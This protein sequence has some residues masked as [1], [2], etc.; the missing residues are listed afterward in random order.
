MKT[1]ARRTRKSA[2]KAP[3]P[4]AKPFFQPIQAKLSV[5]QPGDKLEQEADATADRVLRAPTPVGAGP[6]EREQAQRA[7]EPEEAQRSA[8]PSAEPDEL[9]RS[10]SAKQDE[11]Q[12]SASTEQDE[13]QRSASAEPDELQRSSAHADQDELQRSASTAQDELQ[14]SASAEPDE[15]QRSSTPANGQDELQRT[16]APPTEG[17]ELQRS[18]D[19]EPDELQRKL[20]TEQDELQRSASTE[21]D[22]LQR[23]AT[24]Q[25]D[26]VQRSPARGSEPGLL[27]RAGGGAPQVSESVQAGI[28]GQMT[29][30]RK[31]D[32]P[33]REFMESRFDADFGAVR[34][35]DDKESARL[36]TRLGARA[37]TTRGHIFFGE[38]QYSPGT[39]EGRRLLAH[40]LTHTLQQGVALQRSPQVSGSAPATQVQRLGI[41]DALDYFAD[42]AL[43]LPGFRMLTVVL[44]FNPINMG[45]VDR[46]PGNI[47]RALIELIPGA[48][49]ITSALEKHGVFE[50]AGNWVAQQLAAFAHIGKQITGGIS[51]F[52]DSLSWRD[53]FDL[54]GVWDR[55]KAIF[56]TP[57]RNLIQFGKGLVRGLMDLVRSAILKPLAQLLRPTRGYDLLRALLGRDPVSGEA[58]PRTAETLIGGFMKLIG[59]E[60]LWEN[61]QKGNA[62]ARAW[63]WFQGALGGLMGLVLSIPGQIVAT[64]KSITWQDVLTLVGLVSKLGQLFVSIVGRFFSWGLSTVVELLEILFSV[65]APGVLP[66]LKRAKKAF[67]SILKNPI[68]FVGNLVR[69][70]RLGFQRFQ[71]NIL[72]HLKAALIKWLVGPLAQA[73]VYIPKSFSLVEIVKLVLSVLGL[74]WQALRAKLVK[75]IPEPVLVTLEKSAEILV[76]LAKDG[77]AAA[78]EQIKEEIAE[79]KSS[80]IQEVTT[81]VQVEIVKAAVKKVVS[82]INPA[83]AVVQAILAIY[84]TIQFFVQRISQIAATVGAF[85]HSLAAIA[86]GQVTAAAKRVEETMAN[87]LVV[88]LSFLARLVGLGGI[89]KRLVG[90]V[91]RIRKPIDKG[92][93]RIVAWLGKMLKKL[94]AGAKAKARSLLQWWKKKEPVQADGESHTLLFEG[95]AKNAKLVLRSKPQKPAAYLAAKAKQ[96]SIPAAQ[97]KVSIEAVEKRQTAIAKT[98]SQLAVYDGQGKPTPQ[99]QALTDANKLSAKLDRQIKRLA[100]YIVRKVEAWSGKDAAKL[101]ELTIKRRSFSFS[102]KKALADA[103]R[104]EDGPA[105]MLVKD[106]RGRKVNLAPDLDRRHI[107]S[108]Q[109]MIE[110]YQKALIDKPLVEAKMLLEERGSAPESRVGVQAVTQPSVQAAARKRHRKFFGYTRNLFIGPAAKNRELQEKIDPFKPG[111]S[112]EQLSS[113]VEHIKRLWAFHSSFKPTGFDSQ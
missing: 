5:S 10:A 103:H 99:G 7:A 87:T 56:T 21:P 26:D 106:K 48:T 98:Q 14:R 50:R 16:P 42:K 30:G 84:N 51:R 18:A 72:V 113:H 85:V 77:P 71:G 108:S 52:L 12:R 96:H 70:A 4:S 75:I 76:V 54:G 39:G 37:F 24:A 27:Q 13:I 100:W 8:A 82:M 88:V 102:M 91:E 35:H 1:A 23:S 6:L 11:L 34:V 65:V 49:L 112:T 15:L 101:E 78:W 90:I 60:D 36:S 19:S 63:A 89:P 59:R 53:I 79:L 86:A 25:E 22:E 93:D 111:M 64:L 94:M 58:V 74:S 67:L 109:D 43:F 61:I 104:A 38:G 41:S 28:R 81:M 17:D 62:I 3:E 33:T 46:S 97:S 83:G 107:V 92:M 57:I 55:A 44:G 68:G 105:G 40:E 47:L 69:A 95:K 29:G 31:L 45:K 110:H 73:G 32:E 2:P 20:D 9:Q 80:L 66:Y